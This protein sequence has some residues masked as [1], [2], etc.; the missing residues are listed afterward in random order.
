MDLISKQ[1]RI[2][3]RE[4]L[5]GWMLGTITDLFDAADVAR[6]ELAQVNLSG[7]RRTLV[8]EYYASVDWSS[9]SS[10]RKVLAAY[11][12]VLIELDNPA[13]GLT[14]DETIRA[15]ERKKLLNLLN[16]DGFTFQDGRLKRHNAIDLT[17]V[18]AASALVDREILREHLGR[19]EN[20]VDSDPSLAVGSAKELIE[21]VAKQILHHFGKEAGAT[22]S[23][24]Q[25]SRLQCPRSISRSKRFPNKQ[26]EPLRSSSSWPD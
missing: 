4:H 26:K 19:I 20:R 6:N 3:F 25:E 15:R 17:T 11:E 14:W 18:E 9:P 2:A 10:V 7:Q 24:Q 8:E 21:S 12:Q 13:I 1:T 5:V 22:D 23:L 16:R